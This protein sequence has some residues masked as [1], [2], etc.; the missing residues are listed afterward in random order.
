M[1]VTPTE[2]TSTSLIACAEV[3][4]PTPVESVSRPE[5]LA[6]PIASASAMTEASATEAPSA[7][8]IF[9]PSPPVNSPL[10]ATAAKLT[11]ATESAVI[12]PSWCT[13][14]RPSPASTPVTSAM[15]V[16]SARA[17]A[18]PAVSPSSAKPTVTARL[19]PSTVELASASTLPTSELK[20]RSLPSPP[21]I[22]SAS[23]VAVEEVSVREPPASTASFPFSVSKST[24]TPTVVIS[25]VDLTLSGPSLC[26]VSF[27]APPSKPVAAASAVASARAR[28]ASASSWKLSFPLPPPLFLLVNLLVNSVPRVAPI[29]TES[30]SA[31]ASIS[32]LPVLVI[33][34]R[35]VPPF[36]PVA[37]AR[38]VAVVSDA[39]KEPLTNVPFLKTFWVRLSMSRLTDTP[40]AVASASE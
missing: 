29:A 33:W 35:P 14:F 37:S 16:F 23:E 31:Q 13:S 21:C 1:A 12:T 40:T 9:L 26:S 22:P 32:A 28:T 10:I 2:A 20:S 18:A 19:A 11:S 38:A 34:S 5:P 8:L 27:P 7:P 3:L 39:T 6:R 17:S 24:V 25:A 15:A 30:L 36:T 4:L